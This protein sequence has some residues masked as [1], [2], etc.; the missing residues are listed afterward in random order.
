MTIEFLCPVRGCRQPLRRDGRTFVCSRGHSFDV[1]RS[2][3]VNLSQPQDKKSKNPGDS[4]EAVH[5]RRRLNDAG[6]GE[7]FAKVLV[8]S[9]RGLVSIAEPAILD[10]GCGE[11]FHLARLSAA[12]GGECVGVDLSTRAIELA[13]KRYPAI[14]WIIAN[15]DRQLPFAPGSFDLIASITARHHSAEYRRLL[16]DGGHLVVVIPGADDLIELRQEILGQGSERDRT[17]AVVATYQPHFELQSRNTLRERRR[18]DRPALLDLLVSTYRGGRK[19]Q[20]GR[21]ASLS[22]LEVTMSRDILVLDPRP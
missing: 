12:I 8:E 14:S 21:I 2:G 16:A 6:L 22:D 13:A 1:A 17:E 7:A 20:E 5:A 3:Y 15:A 19:S 4:A 11:G 9:V 18:L 10:V